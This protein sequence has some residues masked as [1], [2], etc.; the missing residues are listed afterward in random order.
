MIGHVNKLSE[1]EISQFLSLNTGWT[2]DG[3]LLSRSFAFPSYAES[4]SF[5]VAVAMA[6]EKR[7][8]HPDI[9][10]SW[11]RVEV[12]WSTHDAGGITALDTE[13]AR[14]TDGFQRA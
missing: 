3:N 13:M 8:H 12:R 9:V 6:A 11:G 1:D 2:R 4:V 10:L 14:K 7:D 5:A